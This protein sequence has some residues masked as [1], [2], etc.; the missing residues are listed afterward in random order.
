MKAIVA[1]RAGGPEVLEYQDVPEPACP[2]AGVL[3]KVDAAGIN[4]I[5]TYLR[6]G[7]YPTSYPHIPGSEGAGTVIAAGPSSKFTTGQRV[8]TSGGIGAYAEIM[9][10]PDDEVVLLPD[11][12]DTQVAAALMLQGMTAHYLC[13][14]AYIIHYGHVALVHAAAGGVGGLLTQLIVA[15]GGR[16]IATAGSAE[17]LALAREYGASDVINYTQ[18]GD[19][20]TEL[21]RAV[22]DLT[23]GEGV[24]VVYDGVGK[25]T[26]DASLASLRRRGLLVLYGGA[27]GQVPAFD[28][29]RLNRAGS[30][31][32]TRPTLGDYV[33]GDGEREWRAGELFSAVLAGRL[34]VPIGGRYQLAQAGDAQAALE[35]RSTTGKVLLLPQ[36]S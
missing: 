6:A 33:V 5:D 1:T 11:G 14:S 23:R 19:L 18:L 29:Q 36:D 30:L 21:P 27:S 13:R 8:A 20:S 7:V 2:E 15:H 17:K 3:V 35:S 32:V 12:L 31:Y 4:F 25:D 26:F 16:V 34:R 28:L 9:A 24:D 10:I 22:R